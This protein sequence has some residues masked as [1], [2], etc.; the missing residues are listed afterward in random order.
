MDFS[1]YLR[2][3]DDPTY[4]L[5]LCLGAQAPA[6]LP[7]PENCTQFLLLTFS[8]L[9]TANM[10]FLKTVIEIEG[11]CLSICT[12]FSLRSLTSVEYDSDSWVTGSFNLSILP[13]AEEKPRCQRPALPWGHP[14]LV[15]GA[16]TCSPFFQCILPTTGSQ[17]HW[18]F[19]I[20]GPCLC[21]CVQQ[22]AADFFSINWTNLST[23]IFGCRNIRWQ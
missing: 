10:R 8:L 12:S 18:D 22:L 23:Y 9:Y 21:F 13:M 5:Q 20:Q 16:G 4:S 15:A 14:A 2:W 6:W 17:L 3:S 11:N 7:S 19:L 1:N